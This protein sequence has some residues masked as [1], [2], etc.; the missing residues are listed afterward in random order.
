MQHVPMPYYLCHQGYYLPPPHEYYQTHYHWV[1]DPRL[2]P[3]PPPAGGGCGGGYYSYPPTVHAP[4]HERQQQ[5]EQGYLSTHLCGAIGNDIGGNA[6]H[7]PRAGP[8]DVSSKKCFNSPYHGASTKPLEPPVSCRE[9]FPGKLHTML[10][11]VTSGSL[12]HYSDAV[13]WLPHGRAFKVL[14]QERFMKYVVPMFFRQ[15]KIRS[16]HRQ[17]YLWGYKK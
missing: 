10:D 2:P 9:H 13:L 16:F 1:A 12:V 4:S 15:T 3:H 7:S 11:L 5:H 8:H 6:S 14:D 17:L